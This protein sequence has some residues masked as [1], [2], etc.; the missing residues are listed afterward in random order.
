[1]SKHNDH[2]IRF[3]LRDR[4]EHII[5]IVLFFGLALTGLPQKFHD[6]EVSK[7]IVN[8]L[9]GIAQVRYLHRLSGVLFAA[10]TL[11]HLVTVMANVVTGRSS[12]AMVPGRKTSG[13]W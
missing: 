11:L 3:G 12:L 13:T 7:A 5:V 4:I 9:G 1:M 2:V 6:S 8:A 10:M